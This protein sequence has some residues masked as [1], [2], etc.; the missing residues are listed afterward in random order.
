MEN[1]TGIWEGEYSVNIGTDGDINIE[2]HTFRI[3][4]LDKK[5]KLSGIAQD[6]TL[7]NEAS[8]ITGFCENGIISFIKKYNRLVFFEDGEYFIDEMEEHPD[9]HYFGT[10]NQNERCYQGT[11]E[12][13]EEEE[14]EGLQE[15][16]KDKYFTGK[17][18]MRKVNEK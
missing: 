10:F 11:W 13:H 17:W 1:L 2:Y 7:S 6:I 14:R 15:E 16:Y 8:G 12:I 9:I 3:D 4:L 5:G 18:Y